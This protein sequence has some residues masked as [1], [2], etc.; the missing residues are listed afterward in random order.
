VGVGTKGWDR[1]IGT[2]PM[3]IHIKNNMWGK[4][5]TEEGFMEAP[6]D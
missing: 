1:L 2:V 6:L 3:L 5:P 4:H